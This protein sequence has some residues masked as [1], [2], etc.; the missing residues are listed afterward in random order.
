M[1]GYE[2]FAEEATAGRFDRPTDDG[3]SAEQIVAHVTRANEA[4]I[5]ATEALLAGE[6]IDYDNREVTDTAV[7]DAYAASYG[8]LRGLAD[9]FAETAAVLRDL[10]GRLGDRGDT[11]VPVRLQDG[12]DVVLDRPVPW[13]HFL[14]INAEQHV[15]G[16]L[17][18][19]RALPRRH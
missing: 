5:A 3:W 18:Q 9:R 10:S 19:L 13:A 16:H 11:P 2:E 7:L 4:L 6:A 17:E 14:R 8:G 12:G 1:D 15:P